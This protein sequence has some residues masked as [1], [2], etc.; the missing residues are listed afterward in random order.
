MYLLKSYQNTIRTKW[1]DDIYTQPEEIKDIFRAMSLKVWTTPS[2]IA[3]ILYQIFVQ[4]TSLE[5]V[6]IK[7]GAS[8]KEIKCLQNEIQIYA[9]MLTSF[10]KNLQKSEYL[11]EYI[12]RFKI[13][14][15]EVIGNGNVRKERKRSG[16]ANSIEMPA[17][18]KMKMNDEV[19]QDKE[20]TTKGK[21]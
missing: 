10:I 14:I 5:E 7:Y 21:W 16:A 4:Q 17:P 11:V 12:E 20:N 8:L 18:T 15:K 1:N 2:F 6:A 3:L 13:H 19:Q 9:D